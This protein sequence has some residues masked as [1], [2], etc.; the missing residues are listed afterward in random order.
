M[1]KVIAFLKKNIYV[2]ELLATLDKMNEFSNYVNK[3]KKNCL[4]K[5]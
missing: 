4:L 1:I 3:I 5:Y 2:N